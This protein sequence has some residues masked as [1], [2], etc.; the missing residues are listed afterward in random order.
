[1]N[2]ATLNHNETFKVRINKVLQQKQIEGTIRTL[3]NVLHN[4]NK[5]IVNNRELINVSSNDYLSLSHHDK[6]LKAIKDGIDIYG[7][8]GAGASPLVT[9]YTKAHDALTKKLAEITKKE[10]IILFG[11]GFSANQA[12]IKALISLDLNLYLDKLVHASMIDA[13]KITSHFKRYPHLNT[14]TLENLLIKTDQPSVIITEGVFSMDGDIA[15]LNTI[16]NIAHKYKSPLILDDAHGFGVLGNGYGTTIESQIDF[17]HVDILMCT[18]S[19]A[20]GVI[21]A[22]IACSK[23]FGEY[24][25]NTSKEL[26]YSTAFPPFIAHAISTSLDIIFSSEGDNLRKILADHIKYL[27]SELNLPKSHLTPIIPIICPTNEYC[28]KCSE[29]LNN[30]GIYAGAIRSPTVPKGTERL[31]ISLSSGLTS[32]ELNQIINSLKEVLSE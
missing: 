15:P 7:T 29:K 5:I 3:K 2:N 32:K 21:G 13:L 22:F 8:S 26:I 12:L 31:R 1:M 9:G 20:I 19:K 14:K 28:L 25:I 18:F 4:K 24:L 10:S 27:I 6:I 11:S 16:S 23:D 17:E 30:L